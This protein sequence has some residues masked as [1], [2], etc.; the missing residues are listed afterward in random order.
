M[1]IRRQ[2]VEA[3][4]LVTVSSRRAMRAAV[5]VGLAAFTACDRPTTAPSWPLTASAAKGD[6]GGPLPTRYV[7]PGSSV[8]P[9]GVAYDQQTQRVFVSSTTDGTVFAGD[10]SDVTL[11]PFLAPGADGRTTAVGL[12]VDNA[13]HLFVAGGAT[14]FVFVYDANTGALIERL[15]GGSSPTFINDIAATRDGVAYVTDSQSPV[16]YR[17]VP[18]GQGGYTIERWLELAGTPIAYTTGFN[19][20]GIVL[21]ANERYLYTIQT[22]TGK[23]YRIDVATKEIVQLDVGG[24]TYPA[25]D[26]LWLQGN[27]LYVLQNQQELITELRVQPNQATATVVSQTTDESFMFPTSL[28]IARGRFLVV[29]S[30]FNNRGG[31]PVLPFTV[32]VIPVP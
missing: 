30:Q 15:S 3:F 2:D 26:G 13:G 11:A 10:V 24:A 22:N 25:G 29:N 31:T 27:S 32:S 28:V 8:F 21:S 5:F 1:V 20:N 16:I 12:E 4:M 23:I 7:L 14:G 9:E 18:D 6:G 19:L 17:L